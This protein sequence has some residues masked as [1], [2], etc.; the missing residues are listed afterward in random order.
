MFLGSRARP[1]LKTDNLTAICEPVLGASTSH[2]SLGL[3]VLLRGYDSFTLL[4][5]V[6]RCLVCWV[7][8]T[9]RSNLLLPSPGSKRKPSKQTELPRQS[10]VRQQRYILPPRPRSLLWYTQVAPGI[11][12]SSGVRTVS[13]AQTDHLIMR[14]TG[15][16]WSS[17]VRNVSLPCSWINPSH[18][19]ALSNFHTTSSRMRRSI[20]S[21]L[22]FL[23]SYWHQ[24]E[25]HP[26]E[27]V[28]WLGFHRHGVVYNL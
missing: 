1:L 14:N 5:Y 28:R 26:R 19:S 7:L 24:C 17:L 16:E 13:L 22:V 25:N 12:I 9:F 18:R 20:A 8:S 6:V 3:H 4:S 11:R 21:V 23:L 10:T 15:R 27:T 2:S